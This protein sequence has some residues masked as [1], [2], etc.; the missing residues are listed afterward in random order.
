MKII[1]SFKLYE[2]SKTEL[3][4]FLNEFGFFIT[5]N[6]SQVTKMGKDTD[7]SRELLEMSRQMRK[8]ILNNKTY[9]EILYDINNI[10][11]SPKLTSA[12]LNQTR[13]LINYIEPRIQKFVKDGDIKNSWL[14]KISRLKDSY[15]KLIFVK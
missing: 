6:L 5:M 7:A 15:K 11:K 2:S 3:I 13:L 4:N 1:K 14:N 8:P 10:I 12:L 9:S